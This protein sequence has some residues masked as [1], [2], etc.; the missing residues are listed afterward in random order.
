MAEVVAKKEQVFEDALAAAAQMP[1][2]RIDRA[3]FL[4]GALKKYCDDEAIELAIEQRPAAARVPRRAIKTLANESINYET[5]KVTA[6]STAAGIPGGLAMIGTVPVD[7]AQYFGHVLRIAQKLAYLYGWPSLFD[8][9]GEMDDGTKSLL[10]LFIGIMFGAEGATKAVTEISKKVAA[11]VVR[12]LPQKALT[13]GVIYPI[14]KKVAMYLGVQMTKQTFAKGV[15]KIVPVIGGVVSG[16]ITL[17]TFRPM[18]A[19][20]RDY[21]AGLP[22]AQPGNAEQKAAQSDGAETVGAAS[23]IIDVEAEVIEPANEPENDASETAE[24]ATE[25]HEEAPGTEDDAEPES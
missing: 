18:S 16:G 13:K 3:A 9:N 22:L 2:V 7:T 17:A 19:T 15:S 5:A 14:V 25:T 1:G 11:S 20:L 21:L 12:L 23:E 10:T 24:P 4:R 8:E 6:I